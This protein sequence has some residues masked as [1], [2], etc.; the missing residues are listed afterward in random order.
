MY[1]LKSEWFKNGKIKDGLRYLD[2]NDSLLLSNGE[3]STTG[4]HLMLFS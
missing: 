1:V 4:S 2:E 3:V